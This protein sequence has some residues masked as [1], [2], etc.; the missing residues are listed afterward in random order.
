MKPYK[1]LTEQEKKEINLETWRKQKLVFEA[2]RKFLLTMLGD[3]CF[4]CGISDSIKKLFFHHIDITKKLFL[5]GSTNI[6]NKN[7]EDLK[8]EVKKCHLYCQECKNPFTRSEETK[9]L[10]SNSR[11]KYL[12][13]NPEKVHWKNSSKFISQPCE[14]LKDFLRKYNIEFEAEFSPNL[15]D[16]HFSIDIAILNKKIAFE[17]NGSQHYDS[18]TGNL[19]PYYQ[20]RQEVLER[21][22]WKVYQIPYLICYNLEKWREFF[23]SI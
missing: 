2:K 17:V 13:E 8:Q 4:I 21:G 5:V 11:K 16:R 23:I 10:I 7:I 14:K 3:K 9:I 6:R 1:T 18:K 22:G 20:D 15:E 19:K 12:K